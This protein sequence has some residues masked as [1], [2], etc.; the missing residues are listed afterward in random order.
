MSTKCI[1]YTS[2]FLKSIPYL[3]KYS[4]NISLSEFVYHGEI[5]TFVSTVYNSIFYSRRKLLELF[6]TNLKNSLTS[7]IMQNDI[8]YYVLLGCYVLLS[9]FQYLFGSL[10]LQKSSE[11]ENIFLKIQA[12]D[13]YEYYK[14]TENFVNSARS[15]LVDIDIDNEYD[16][17][18]NL[19]NETE[20]NETHKGKTTNIG[21]FS[22]SCYEKYEFTFRM[23]LS[24]I[25]SV[26]CFIILNIINFEHKDMLLATKDIAND[27]SRIEYDG[28]ANI[29]FHQ[30]FLYVII[31]KNVC[32]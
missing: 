32:F 21:K 22:Y 29:V 30:Y 15:S 11:H 18:E 2:I 3:I 25:L 28:F 27:T 12:K 7:S 16:S 8:I 31:T 6:V 4:G 14:Q 23:L 13:S 20:F 17:D 5:E 10:L 19:Q 24:G 1:F 9:I 26:T